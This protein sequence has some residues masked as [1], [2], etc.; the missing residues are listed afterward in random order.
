MF[1]LTFFTLIF[2]FYMWTAGEYA[3]MDECMRQG[4]VKHAQMETAEQRRKP[5]LSFFCLGPNKEV[6]QEQL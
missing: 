1:E 3:T 4:Y 6:G 5:V 2:P